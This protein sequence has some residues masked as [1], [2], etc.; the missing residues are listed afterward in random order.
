MFVP[1]TFAEELRRDGATVL[2]PHK[3]ASRLAMSV[4]ELATIAGVHPD[5]MSEHPE[6]KP[7]Q[8]LMQHVVRVI[9][10]AEEVS[11]DRERAL[12][13]LKKTTLD[14]FGHKTPL[15]LIADGRTDVLVRYLESIQSGYVG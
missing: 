6:S 14:S 10:A 5:T 12:E 4:D 9:S 11:G 15:A 1:I 8:A 3:L 13:W 2:S 7:V